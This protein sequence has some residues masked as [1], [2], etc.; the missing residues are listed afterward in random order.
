MA[1]L[2]SRRPVQ[3]DETR[4]LHLREFAEPERRRRSLGGDRTDL[5][6]TL[7]DAVADLKQF[8]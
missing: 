1:A 8:R 6:Q 2:R 4:Q 5:D 7:L 3:P